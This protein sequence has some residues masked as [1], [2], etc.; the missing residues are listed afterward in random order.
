LFPFRDDLAPSSQLT[1]L[2][3]ARLRK[4]LSL[5]ATISGA[6]FRFD[7]FP[8]DATALAVFAAIAMQ[9]PLPEKQALLSIESVNELLT[10]EAELL[11]SEVLALS[12]MTRS[13]RPKADSDS[14]IF[15]VN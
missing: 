4:Y 13:V 15:S 7:Q 10:R 2:V 11:K 6:K 9:L 5:L 3:I 8:N 12:I 1:N 14:F